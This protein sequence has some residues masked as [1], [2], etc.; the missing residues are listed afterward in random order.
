VIVIGSD[1][2]ACSP[3]AS[4]EMTVAKNSKFTKT[5]DDFSAIGA[6]AAKKKN[7]SVSI[8]LVFPAVPFRRCGSRHHPRADLPSS[9]MKMT[10]YQVPTP[11]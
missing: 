7:R 8:L 1:G 3:E 10:H 9:T 11:A 2:M 6:L 5:R 4:V